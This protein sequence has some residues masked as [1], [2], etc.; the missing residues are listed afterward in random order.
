MSPFPRDPKRIRERIKRYERDLASEKR[1]FGGYDDS[2]GKRYL[3][4]PLYLLLG[5]VDGARKSFAWFQRTFPEDMGEPFQ[6]L[7]W[8]LALY[9]VGDHD[10]AAK[11]LVQTWFQNR[12]LV[13]RLLGRDEQQPA[14]QHSTNWEQPEYVE[15]G[16]S[17]L[18][19]L[20]GESAL[21]WARD[22]YETAWFKEVRA[23]YLEIE[24]RL[25]SE[26]VGPER[27]RLVSE[28]FRLIKLD[29][30]ETG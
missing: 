3:L 30:V 10:N 24:R 11:K 28:R 21:L 22:V 5:D 16:P 7:C 20:W 2:T 4:G 27:S 1:R 17:E 9:R 14:I 29:G 26:P 15:H 23:T 12:Y 8:T 13:S 25:E 6:Y 18:L 19:D